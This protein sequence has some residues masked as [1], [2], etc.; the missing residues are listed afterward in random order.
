MMRQVN[1]PPCIIE[2]VMQVERHDWLIPEL[3][4]STRR[5]WLLGNGRRFEVNWRD[6]VQ[7]TLILPKPGMWIH[8]RLRAQ[9]VPSGSWMLER[10][11]V[12]KP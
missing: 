3:E 11:V 12:L 9:Q 1:N 6:W 4:S 10:Y 5:I 7:E 8:A 2:A